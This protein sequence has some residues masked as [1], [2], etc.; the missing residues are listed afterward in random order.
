MFLISDAEPGR[1]LEDFEKKQLNTSDRLE[2]NADG[3]EYSAD[4]I[5]N[6]VSC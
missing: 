1:A 4:I 2:S 6:M 3:G 5:L